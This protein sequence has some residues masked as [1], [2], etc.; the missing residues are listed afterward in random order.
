MDTCA[1]LGD[2][3]PKQLQVIFKSES[4]ENNKMIEREETV[5]SVTLVV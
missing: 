5:N 4:E 2:C 3:I 1:T